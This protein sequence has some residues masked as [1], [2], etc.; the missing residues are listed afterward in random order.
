[1]AKFQVGVHLRPQHTD[2]KTLR[3]AWKAVDQVGADVITT[4]DHFF[5]LR[6]DPAGS[7]FE[8]WTMLAAMAVETSRARFGPMVSCVAYRN[9]NLIADMSR[10]IDHLS[11]GRFNLGLG[12]GNSER[13][14]Q[15]FGF[16]FGPPAERLKRLESSVQL[17][18]S[19]LN[20]LNP[21]PLGP[22]PILIGGAGEKV[23][24]RLA[25]QHADLWNTP[26]AANV[27]AEKNRILD[28]WCTKVGRDPKHIQRSASIPADAVDRA[29]EW[30]EAG[31]Q[32]LILQCDSPFDLKPVERLL[33]MAN[34]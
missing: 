34:A 26:A 18:K 11:G 15:E 22:L 1:M 29:V 31:A 27:W 28:D 19:R 32:L 30:V 6:G 14:H 13:D 4:W 5:P 16:H 10:T 20:K 33:E 21:P 9:P 23:T 17:I 8:C 12:A 2:I 7:H 24:L 25:A 3:Q